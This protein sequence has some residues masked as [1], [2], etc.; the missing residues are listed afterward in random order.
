VVNELAQLC[1]TPL[2]IPVSQRQEDLWRRLRRTLDGAVAGLPPNAAVVLAVD[3]ADNA[4]TAARECGNRSF[5]PELVRLTLPVR[6]SVV[7]TARSHRVGSL[8]ATTAAEEVPLAVFDAPT[9]AAHLRRHRPDASEEEAHAFHDRTQGN[10]RAQFYALQ[11]AAE[12]A[13]DMSTL[14]AKSD[15]TPK[16]VFDDLIDSA[17]Q[18]GGADAGGLRWLALM[19][20]LSRPV[21]LQTLATALDVD[22]PAVR[23]FAAGLAPGVRVVDDSIQFR[24]EDFE[25]HVRECVDPSE[26]IAAHSRLADL[27]LAAR[28]TDVD[29][30]AHVADHLAASGRFEELLQLVLEEASPV[31]ITD[32]FRR[33]EVQGRRLDL[34]VRAAAQTATRQPPYDWLF[35]VVT[36]RLVSAH[37]RA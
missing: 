8:E 6:V 30:A 31:G 20:A 2:L 23:N 10:P 14:L 21:R 37:C 16:A 22:L 3:A 34:A 7:L 4:A 26:V 11:Q 15:R 24:D 18:V 28:A 9:S 5:L 33:E 25:T 17:L 36:R 1:G 13:W 35:E 19:L 12:H 29:A 27:C 32:G